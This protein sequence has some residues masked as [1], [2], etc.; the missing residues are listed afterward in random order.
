MAIVTHFLATSEGN[1][2]LNPK[3]L[4]AFVKDLLHEQMVKFPAA[5]L[6]GEA[7]N[8]A[9]FQ[10]SYAEYETHINTYIVPNAPGAMLGHMEEKQRFPPDLLWYF[11]NDAQVF[12]DV[13]KQLPLQEKDCCICFGGVH[14]QLAQMYWEGAV[15]YLLT[16]PFPMEFCDP[17]GS[18]LVTLVDRPLAH[19]FLLF[20]SIGGEIGLEAN[21]LDPI[22]MRYFGP[23]LL[24]RET[25]DL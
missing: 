6:V 24:T 7:R 21:P 12:F 20:S 22:L 10:M 19:Y 5:I 17:I 15:I 16:H 2:T 25:I 1:K 14:E 8:I 9:S 4:E 13:L 3:E 11:G 23:H 18:N